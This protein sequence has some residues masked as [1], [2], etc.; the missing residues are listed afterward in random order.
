[1]VITGSDLGNGWDVTG[2]TLCGIPATILTQSSTQI[3]VRAGTAPEARIGDVRVFSTSQ[4]ETSKANAFAYKVPGFELRNASGI[5]L[6]SGASASAYY[7]TDF[8]N[9]YIGQSMTNRFT[10]RNTGAFDLTIGNVVL[11]GTDAGEFTLVDLAATIPPGEADEFAIVFSPGTRAR[12]S[13]AVEIPNDSP[14][15]PFIIRLAGRGI[16][17]APEIDPLA[18]QS[19]SEGQTVTFEPE[20]VGAAPF[21]FLWLKNGMAIPG[22]NGNVSS[23]PAFRR[24]T[25][26][27]TSS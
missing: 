12:F 20:V 19:V 26:D 6:P 15:D 18:S 2:V 16:A 27:S 25:P 3:V 23:C 1:M 21:F 11:T 5:L 17:Y 8:G 9:C 7:G 13:L 24:R 22:A 14:S 10:I 4:G